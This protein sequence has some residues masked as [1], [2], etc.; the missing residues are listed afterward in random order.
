MRGGRLAALRYQAV[1]RR[2]GHTAATGVFSFSCVSPTVYRRLR[3]P[4][5]FADGHRPCR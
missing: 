5:V 2:D 1:V 4:H 3:P